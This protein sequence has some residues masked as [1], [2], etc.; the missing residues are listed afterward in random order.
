MWTRGCKEVYYYPNL[1]KNRN[2]QQSPN[3]LSTW[4]FFCVNLNKSRHKFHAKVCFVSLAF[5]HPHTQELAGWGR[6]GGR[7]S[8]DANT[9][10][11]SHTQIMQSVW[12]NRTGLQFYAASKNLIWRELS[13][14][15][16]ICTVLEPGIVS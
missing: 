9:L 4:Y 10:F 12:V 3:V 13:Q 8:T 5:L 16:W 1:N 7:G 2:I 15:V 6:R 14:V 11:P